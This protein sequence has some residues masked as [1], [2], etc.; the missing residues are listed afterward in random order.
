MRAYWRETYVHISA[1]ELMN[2]CMYFSVCVC[3]YVSVCVCACVH[4]GVGILAPMRQL[5]L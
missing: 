2:I 4:T 3:V 1:Y 5:W